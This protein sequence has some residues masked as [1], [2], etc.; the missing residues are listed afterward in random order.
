MGPPRSYRDTEKMAIEAATHLKT[1]QPHSDITV[2][3][4]ETQGHRGQAPAPVTITVFLGTQSDARIG[5]VDIRHAPESGV[6]ADIAGGPRRGQM[7]RL[8]H[9]WIV[10]PATQS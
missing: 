6:K 9:R 10:H 4:I 1:K 2:R 3:D 8:S 7:P 5:R